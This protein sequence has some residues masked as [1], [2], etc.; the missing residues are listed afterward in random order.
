MKGR[1]LPCIVL[2][3]HKGTQGLHVSRTNQGTKAGQEWRPWLCGPRRLWILY[4]STPMFLRTCHRMPD[5]D[6]SGCR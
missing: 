4:S 6:S 5:L 2:F 3:G 1:E